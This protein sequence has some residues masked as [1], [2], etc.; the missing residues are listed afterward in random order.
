MNARE[1]VAGN[2]RLASLPDVYINVKAVLDD[3]D[4]S[5]VDMVRAIEH[6]PGITARL[7]R[8]AN[9]AF[10]GFAAKVD[11]VSRAV[12]LLG[13]QQ[14]HDL[15]LAT[16]LASVFKGVPPELV[17]MDA[18]WH[19]SIYRAVAAKLLAGHCNVLDAERL[20]V[21]GLLSDIGHLILYQVVPHEA[22]AALQEALQSDR[23]LQ[24]VEREHLGY[25]FA[26][27]GSELLAAWNLPGSLVE[28]V[29]HHITPARAREFELETA[30]VHIAAQVAR[31]SE[32]SDEAMQLDAA[33]L[34]I[35]G[36]SEAVL[37]GLVEQVDKQ[38]A[39]AVALIFSE[40]R[41][42]A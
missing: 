23:P 30:I 1:L 9:S 10:F 34:R 33:A 11:T 32:R 12:S 41:N 29:R 4:S 18:F 26:E 15:V 14:I 31:A 6:D 35:T 36:L 19:R 21:A 7:L 42:V 22:Q 3:P 38:V 17:D 27:V 28:I 25:D 2:L 37:E 40:R 13:T 24:A 20:F 8:I 39:E 5:V 16:S